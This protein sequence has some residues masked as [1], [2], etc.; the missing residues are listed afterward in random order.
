MNTLLA[1]FTITVW[2]YFI[3]T[4]IINKWSKDKIFNVSFMTIVF[5]LLIVVIS[6]LELTIVNFILFI[7]YFILAHWFYTDFTIFIKIN[8]YFIKRQDNDTKDSGDSI[9][10]ALFNI[11]K[12]ELIWINK[13]LYSMVRLKNIWI[14]IILFTYWFILYFIYILYL[15]DIIN[16]F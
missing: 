14:D 7:L 15:L 11:I 3:I 2:Y 4:L 10:F 8:E 5:L 12:R 6:F 9:Q 1:I 13:E 16:L